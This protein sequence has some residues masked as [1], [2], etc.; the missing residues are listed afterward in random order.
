MILKVVNIKLTR[1]LTRNTMVVV[2]FIYFQFKM[3]N[4]F[5]NTKNPKT[6]I[7][8]EIV[9][10]HGINQLIEGYQSVKVQKQNGQAIFELEVRNHE[11]QSSCSYLLKLRSNSLKESFQLMFDDG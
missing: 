5:R 11:V 3:I 8:C 2:N 4:F 7:Q 1:F 6:E 10:G 9:Y